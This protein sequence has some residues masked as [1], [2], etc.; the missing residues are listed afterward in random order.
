MLSRLSVKSVFATRTLSRA[1]C[2]RFSRDHEWCTVSEN[3]I[4]TF[5]ITK[6]AQEE[7]GEIVFVDFQTKVG[8]SVE[9]KTS[10]A[11]VESVKA[12]SD[13]YA[14]ISGKLVEFNNELE[15][16]LDLINEEPQA[17]GWLFKLQLENK[18]EFNQLMNQTEY[19]KFCQE[20]HH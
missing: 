19:E 17:N 4:A 20:E 8:E 16:N 9:A 14:P 12:V 10:A 3:N 15:S 11:S 13:V 6:H 5:G 2:T 7:L 18:N 1:F